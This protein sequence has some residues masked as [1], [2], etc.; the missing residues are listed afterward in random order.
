MRRIIYFSNKSVHFWNF[1]CKLLALHVL[2]HFV[3]TLIAVTDLLESRAL[4][5][6]AFKNGSR[7]SEFLRRTES[8]ASCAQ[9]RGYAWFK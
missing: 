8:L 5:V 3:N 4:L 7:Q 1:Y 9:L 6:V 2:C